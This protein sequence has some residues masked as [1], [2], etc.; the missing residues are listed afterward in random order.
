MGVNNKIFKFL[1]KNGRKNGIEGVFL[2]DLQLNDSL[3]LDF[4][5]C[6]GE[7]MQVGALASMTVYEPCRS[8]AD[9]AQ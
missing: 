2:H 3:G 9:H 1:F 5:T 8:F 4:T 7:L 6:C